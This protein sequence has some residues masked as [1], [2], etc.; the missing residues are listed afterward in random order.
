LGGHIGFLGGQGFSASGI[1]DALNMGSME[2]DFS[3][4]SRG[5][6]WALF[7]LTKS[8]HLKLG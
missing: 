2:I 6:G 4:R 8:G 5:S 7:F 3:P 1:F